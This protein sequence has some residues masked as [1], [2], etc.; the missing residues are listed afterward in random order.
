MKKRLLKLDKAIFSGY[1]ITDYAKLH[2]Y[3]LYYDYFK[4][5]YDTKHTSITYLYGDTDSIFYYVSAKKQSYSLLDPYQDMLS[6]Y[7]NIMDLSNFP[8]TS[9]FYNN[10]NAGVMGLL[11]NETVLPISE[12]V[13]LKCKMYALKYGSHVKKTAKGVKSSALQNIT[14]EHYKSVLQTGDTL[15]HIQYNIL[16]KKRSM[17][18]IQ[19]NKISLSNFYDK[20]YLI[21]NNH[22]LPLGHYKIT[23]E[24]CDELH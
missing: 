14:F 22:S 8:I 20:R 19:Q 16:P 10:T 4:K 5:I 11:K 6:K 12:W 2:M 9:E 7:P 3:K 23:Q 17:N 1:L 18:T 24:I 21:S 13:G 15:R